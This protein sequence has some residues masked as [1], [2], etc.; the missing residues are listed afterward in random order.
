MQY[1]VLPPFNQDVC[2]YTYI[3]HKEANI[4]IS[5]QGFPLMLL[6]IRYNWALHAHCTCSRLYNELKT[7]S[8]YMQLVSN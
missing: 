6:H 7:E 5:L 8:G 3:I 1:G 2:S 4:R